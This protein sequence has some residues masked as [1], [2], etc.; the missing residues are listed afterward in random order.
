MDMSKK[1]T[2]KIGA[3]VN[4]GASCMQHVQIVAPELSG[5]SACSKDLPRLAFLPI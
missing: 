2:G 3:L 4:Y 5:A 1:N